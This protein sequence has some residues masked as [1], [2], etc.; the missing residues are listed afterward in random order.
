MRR[1]RQQRRRGRPYRRRRRRS[2]SCTPTGR[3]RTD[4]VERR[5]RERDDGPVPRVARKHGRGAGASLLPRGGR[6]QPPRDPVRQRVLD[7]RRSRRARP[8]PS[9]RPLVLFLLRVS[10]PAPIFF[11]V[12]SSISVSP[13][14]STQAPAQT[15]SSEPR[16][17]DT[18]PYTRRS[19]RTAFLFALGSLSSARRACSCSRSSRGPFRSSLFSTSLTTSHLFER[20]PPTFF[21]HHV[22]PVEISWGGSVGGSEPFRLSR[23]GRFPPPPFLAPH[24]DADKDADRDEDGD[25]D[26]HG[27]DER[28]GIVVG[29]ARDGLPPVRYRDGR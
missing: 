22:R 28:D 9:E 20:A 23:G 10:S 24:N 4:A 25:E 14:P 29:L 7:D 19:P 13:P 26:R 15:C 27:N 16:D 18:S 2:C 8:R 21:S 17:A 12:V 1:R 3:P 11:S 6:R 5:R